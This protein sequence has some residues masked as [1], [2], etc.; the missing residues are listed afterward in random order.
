M[1]LDI[2]ID[3]VWRIHNLIPTGANGPRN[4]YK[5]E[6]E[7]ASHLNHLN[8]RVIGGACHGNDI[9]FMIPGHPI[10]YLETKHNSNEF[11]GQ[12]FDL[13]DDH[14]VLQDSVIRSFISEDYVP[15]GGRIP[16]FLRGD[17][18]VAT[19]E[20]ERHLFRDEYLDLVNI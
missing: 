14:L 4:G 19:W 17:R 13:I 3:L 6:H 9:E 16:S 8:A 15:F 10:T 11:G 1:E 5:Y 2:F 12:R 7:I 20:K 18:T